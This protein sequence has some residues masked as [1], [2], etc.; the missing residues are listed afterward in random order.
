MCLAQQWSIVLL[1][2][3]AGFINWYVP[4]TEDS[5]HPLL[6]PITYEHIEKLPKAF[7]VVSEKDEIKQ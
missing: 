6:L 5:S 2:I 4:V 3:A 1:T 7:I